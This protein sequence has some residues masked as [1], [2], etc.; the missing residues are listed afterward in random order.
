MTMQSVRCPDCGEPNEQGASACLVCGE[1]LSAIE[2][3][4]SMLDIGAEQGTVE[5]L[6]GG[7]P[8]CGAPPGMECDPECPH[9][10]PMG[11]DPDRYRESVSHDFD[12]FM[13]TTLL[14]E[15]RARTVDAKLLT[16]QRTLARRRQ[17]NPLGKIKVGGR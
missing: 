8:E 7:C 4:G 11:P 6:E 16:P 9:A 17:E 1:D 13:D 2:P 12:K 15:E 3:S 5:D 14:K 10:E